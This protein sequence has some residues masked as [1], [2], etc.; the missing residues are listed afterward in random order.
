[1]HDLHYDRFPSLKPAAGDH[2][3]VT[4]RII[5]TVGCHAGVALCAQ[6]KGAATMLNSSTTSIPKASQARV[7]KA[8][9]HVR[10]RIFRERDA[11]RWMVFMGM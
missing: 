8:G 11:D 2:R 9:E 7:L 5:G 4:G 3:G 6:S 10:L 1:M